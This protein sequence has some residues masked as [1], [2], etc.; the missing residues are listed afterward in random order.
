MRDEAV[1]LAEQEG[2][3]AAMARLG[4]VLIE[5]GLRGGLAAAQA[6]FKAGERGA[7]ARPLLWIVGGRVHGAAGVCGAAA[8]GARM[9]SL[10]NS[11]MTACWT[12]RSAAAMAVMGLWKISPHREK[13]RLLVSTTERCS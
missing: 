10:V 1:Q 8:P 2:E 12:K 11:R 9:P 4:S 7:Q 13:T 3:F 5:E 6:V